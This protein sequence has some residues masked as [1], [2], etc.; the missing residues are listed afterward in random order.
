M[1]GQ[2]KIRRGSQDDFSD[3]NTAYNVANTGGGC[4]ENVKSCISL[5]FLLAL[6]GFIASLLA[7]NASAQSDNSC[8]PHETLYTTE[9]IEMKSSDSRFSATRGMTKVFQVYRVLEAK[10]DAWFSSSCWVRI[11]G[12]WMLRRPTGSVI[13]PGQPAQQSTS[14]STTTS[15]NTTSS[16][17]SS[18][19]YT[20]SKAYIT[21]SM[22]IRSGPSTSNGKVGSANSGESFTVSSSQRGGDYCWLRISK[23]W[24]AKTP[25]VRST[26]PPAYSPSST[27]TAGLPRIEGSNSF[28]TKAIRAWNYLRDKSSKWFS[29]AI[30]ANFSVIR[31]GAGTGVWVNSRRMEVNNSGRYG[32]RFEDPVALSSVFIHEAC[33]IY[34]WNQGRHGSLGLRGRESE[35]YGIQADAMSEYAPHAQS[36]ITETRR[37]AAN[38]PHLSG[39]SW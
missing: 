17:V 18:G 25:R 29:Y 5:I 2:Y 36:L 24:I 16:T 30:S 3:I 6:C 21:G 28:R 31:E 4:W 23:G 15:S 14:T 7:G 39:A 11:S 20:G 12:G 8:F 10:K 37:L 34:Q 32:R 13:R 27:N 22:N 9:P 33:H 26:K 19:C 35:C 1:S 38:P